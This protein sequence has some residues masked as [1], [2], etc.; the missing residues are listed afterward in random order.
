MYDKGMYI[1]ERIEFVSI[2][3]IFIVS[4]F[5]KLV[6]EKNFSQDKIMCKGNW[7]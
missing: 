6:I 3:Y 2:L 1:D 7:G 5:S 4:I